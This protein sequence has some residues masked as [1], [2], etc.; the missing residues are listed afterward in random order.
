MLLSGFLALLS[1]G[2]PNSAAAQQAPA[3]AATGVI[4]TEA[5][6]ETLAEEVR[7]YELLQSRFTRRTSVPPTQVGAV[8]FQVNA[9]ADLGF[10]DNLFGQDTNV[11]SAFFADYGAHLDGDYHY[12]GFR[13]HLA[14]GGQERHYFTV[15]NE[16]YWQATSRL[17][18][19]EQFSHD[20]GVFL[21]GGLERL[22]VPRTDPNEINGF[23]PATYLLYDAETGTQ[24]GDGAHNLLTV[25]AG[26][27]QS[28][29][30]QSFGSQGLI[31][32][33]DRDR[34]EFFGDVRFDHTF[35][36][37]QK[38]FIEV[39]PDGRSFGR[40]IDTSGFKRASNGVR[41]D[42]G[43]QFDINNLFLITLSS[44]Y[45]VQSYAD[46]RYGQINV[47]DVNAE[48][49]WS[50]TNLTQ[51]DVKYVH[52][53]YEDLFIESPGYT[54]NMTTVTLSHELLRELLLKAD[55]SYDD[56]QLERSVRHYD[57]LTSEVRADYEIKHGLTVGIDYTNQKLD[58]NTARTFV[59]NIVMMT[60]KKQF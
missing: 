38:V 47:P 22:A 19:S 42:A 60:L 59:D 53:Y 1:A 10:N 23:K 46:P 34:R 25:T 54:H 48:V 3:P 8:A 14:L 36:G 7:P 58:S 27:N 12:D 6:S 32:T 2:K 41:T 31:I 4:S 37:Q 45:Q 20:F 57:I 21:D 9:V 40:D 18:L 29:Y 30:D 35:F 16:D 5:T 13:A 15:T 33:N 50:P 56:R 49:L 55:V 43:V 44:G 24:I 52:E 17:E 26:Y 11:K 51:V 39:R 28:I